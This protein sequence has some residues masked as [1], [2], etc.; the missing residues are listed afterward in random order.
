MRAVYKLPPTLGFS[1]GS[2]KIRNVVCVDVLFRWL[3]RE[4][5]VFSKMPCENVTD[6]LNSG[7]KSCLIKH[8]FKRIRY[9]QLFSYSA[10]VIH[11]DS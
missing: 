8:D 4:K 2:V 9:A 11:Y 6:M 7:L 1:V 3:W 10:D 5:F